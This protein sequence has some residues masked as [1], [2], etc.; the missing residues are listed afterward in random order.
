MT[1][2]VGKLLRRSGLGIATAAGLLT[3]GGC[4]VEPAGYAGGYG[5]GYSEPY[6][7]PAP[8]YVGPTFYYGHYHT[9]H[10]NDWHHDDWHHNDWHHGGGWNGGHHG[11]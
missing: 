11:H 1:E 4:V 2:S 7:A 5:Y 6:Y 10:H 9:W 3:L 8:V